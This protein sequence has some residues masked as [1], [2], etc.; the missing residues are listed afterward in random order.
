MATNNIAEIRKA[1]GMSQTE[2]AEAIGTTLNNLGKLER[3]D[4]RLNQDWI[5]KI[6][7]ATGVAPHEVIGPVGAQPVATIPVLGEVPAGNWREAIKKSSAVMYA[8]EPDMPPAAYALKVTGDSMDLVVE[9]GATIV[10]DP[11]DLDLYTNRYYVVDN[12]EGEATFKQYKDQ[13]ARL[14]PCSSN[15]THKEI[16]VGGGEFRIVGRVI[17]QGKRM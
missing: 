16:P 8:P 10:I 12:G 7:K 6:A 4:R 11:T 1:A 13:P 14:V 2:L 17:W 9:D 5:N 15:P 3:G